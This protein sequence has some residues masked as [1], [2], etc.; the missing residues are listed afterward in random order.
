MTLLWPRRKPGAAAAKRV[1][2]AEAEKKKLQIST[3]LLEQEFVKTVEDLRDAHQLSQ[4]LTR[5]VN[6]LVSSDVASCLLLTC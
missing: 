5:R 3:A 4:A 6:E 2:N 1:Q